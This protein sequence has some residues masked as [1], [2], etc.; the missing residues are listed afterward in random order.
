MGVLGENAGSETEVPLAER[1]K[2]YARRD[3]IEAAGAKVVEL[4]P[5]NDQRTSPTCN[6]QRTSPSG[7][8]PI[9]PPIN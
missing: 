9:P 3:R 1:L 7:S 5:C 6:D 2:E 8:E 4:N